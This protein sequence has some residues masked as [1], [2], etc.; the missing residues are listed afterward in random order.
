MANF[1]YVGID[2]QKHQGN[3]DWTKAARGQDFVIIRAGY[4]RLASQEDLCFKKNVEGAS[5]AGIKYI[6]VYW[7]S[8]AATASE[9]KLEAQVCLKVIEPYKDIINLPIWFD[10]EYEPDIL[11]A[12]KTVRTNCVLEFC[13]AVHNA[14]YRTGLYASKDWFENK[15]TTSQFPSYFE[16]WVAQYG[17]NFTYKGDYVAWQY[18]STGRINGIS[19]N[20]DLNRSVASLIEKTS[21]GKDGWVK[22]G[23][24]WYWY[25][26]GKPVSN[27][28]RKI[29]GS[30]GV[31]YWYY[32]GPDGKMLKGMQKINGKVYYLNPTAAMGVPEGAL[33]MTDQNGVVDRG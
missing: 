2:V 4:G 29:T 1:T 18:S 33:I 9:A 5:N 31:Y 14:G 12:T 26:N 24:N 8:Y 10:Q 3:I 28:W 15:V 13:K 11:N 30:S 25:E 27:C 19:G 17:A 23:S 6:G 22:S 20:V 32:L 21:S 7:Y 16:N